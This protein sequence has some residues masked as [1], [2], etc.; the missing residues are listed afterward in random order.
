MTMSSVSEIFCDA[1]VIDDMFDNV[2]KCTDHVL[3]II[4]ERPNVHY[5]PRERSHN[6]TLIKT[7]NRDF[8][9]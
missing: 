7:V 9:Q 8:L 1:D 6:K 4:P 2:L 5:H 3:D